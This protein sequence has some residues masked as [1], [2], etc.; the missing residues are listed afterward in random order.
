MLARTNMDDAR[1]SPSPDLE[2]LELLGKGGMG[3]VWKARSRASGQLVALKTALVEHRGDV[4]IDERFRREARAVAQIEHPN[5]CRLV[6]HGEAEGGFYLA[7]EYIDGVSVAALKKAMGGRLPLEVA[8]AIARAALAGL[9]VAHEAGV[10]H[11][12]IKPANVMVTRAGVAKL[13]DFGIARSV[14]DATLTGTGSIVGTPGFL[15]PE[16]AKGE[17]VTGTS[18]LFSLGA[19]LHD[20]VGGKS[21]FVGESLASSLLKVTRDRAP[22]LSDAAEGVPLAIDRWCARLM[23]R[24][25]SR[26]F[27][28]AAE[29]LSVLEALGLSTREADEQLLAQSVAEPRFMAGRLRARRVATL[30]AR[31]ERLREEGAGPVSIRFAIEEASRLSPGDAKVTALLRS[32]PPMP[33]RDDMASLRAAEAEAM[34]ALGRSESPVLWRHAARVRLEQGDVRGAVSALRHAILLRATD[35][36]LAE[37]DE[38]TRPDADPSQDVAALLDAALSAPEPVVTRREEG[39][40]R[41]P[42]APRPSDAGG[43]LTAA[44]PRARSSLVAPP[45]APPAVR[46]WVAGAG[47][48]GLGLALGFAAG[49][50]VGTPRALPPPASTTESAIPVDDDRGP[51]P[52]LTSRIR[53]PAL[54]NIWLQGCPDCM[55]K[56]NA[57]SSLVAA[58]RLPRGIDVH[59]VAF[60]DATRDYAARYHVDAGLASDRGDVYVKPLGISTFTTLLVDGE[61]RV[62]ERLDPTDTRYL[63]RVGRF[64][65]QNPRRR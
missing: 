19:S 63:G 12:D 60:G 29:A 46:P 26:R 15:S 7:L 40:S 54:V 21:P 39:P 48:L 44:E 24:E 9:A 16:Q 43:A 1:P 56:F 22:P 6:A 52:V 20:L 41:A 28:S 18:D 25:P 32:I 49:L 35:E 31:A 64:A 38:I 30:L 47:L 5:L 62:L 55:P 8:L 65:D 59:N 3:Q 17:R 37:H 14:G 2:I 27:T 33:R 51:V 53:G 58:G 50:A 57:W 10:V 23:E 4:E 34:D 11:R 61:G 13:L 42:L 36:L 45:A